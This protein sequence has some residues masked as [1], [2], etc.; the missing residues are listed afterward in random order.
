MKKKLIITLLFL[1]SI[2]ATIVI[3]VYLIDT[4]ETPS[5][6]NI[7]H[8]KS[9][10]LSEEREIIVRTPRGYEEQGSTTY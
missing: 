10:I 5:S 4:S 3:T 9:I 1:F 6:Y 8:I 7:Y 2:M